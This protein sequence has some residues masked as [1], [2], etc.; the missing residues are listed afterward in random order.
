AVRLDDPTAVVAMHGFPA[1]W[2]LLA[3]GIFAD[4]RIGEGWNRVSGQR[5]AGYVAAAWP[6]QFQ[7]QATGVIAVVLSAFVLSW[8]LFAT[9]QG[10]THAWPGE[11]TIRPPRRLRR[12]R[13]SRTRKR[14]WSGPR[15]RFVRRERPEPEPPADDEPASESAPSGLRAW[16]SSVQSW[17]QG[18]GER[19]GKLLKREPRSEEPDGRSEAKGGQT[20]ADG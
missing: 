5:V 4:G 20:T 18:A 9:I 15:I 12:L 11:S 2:G 3:V 13:R 6:G 1:L 10:L 8:L 19:V 16:L 14:A 17:G 7:A